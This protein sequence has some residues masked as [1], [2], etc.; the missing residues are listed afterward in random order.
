MLAAL[1][2][3][4]GARLVHFSTD[5]VFDGEK[6]F[7]TES[8]RV[9]PLSV[10][11]RSKAASEL[12]ATETCPDTVVL[13]V[14]NCYGRPLGALTCF[15]DHFR[16]ALSAGRSMPG[17]TDQWRTSTA[18]D[19]LPEAMTRLLAQPVLRGI[20]HWAGADRAS[21]YEA[22]ILFCR[23]MGFDEQLIRPASASEVR[24]LAT[25]P[26]DTSLDSS[27]LAAELGLAPVSLREGFEALGGAWD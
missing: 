22:A 21:R 5:L 27:R 13:R 1:C 12:A 25:R 4:H 15:V 10:Y 16:A 24:F 8:D 18:A 6:G 20:F 19:W 9:H 14:A 26:R 11:G 7:Y 17:L 23:A 2:H 3:E